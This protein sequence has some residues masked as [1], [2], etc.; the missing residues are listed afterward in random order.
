[1]VFLDRE[2]ELA[3]LGNHLA[4]PGAGLFVLYGRR[5]IGKT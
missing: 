4:R 1:M 5:R 2:Y 3:M